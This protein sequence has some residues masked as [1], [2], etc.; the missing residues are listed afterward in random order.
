MIVSKL[1]SFILQ[2]ALLDF[3]T[4]EFQEECVIK[5]ELKEII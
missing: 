5:L 1:S 2:P 4:L 3:L